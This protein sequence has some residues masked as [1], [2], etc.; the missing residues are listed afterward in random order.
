[1]DSVKKIEAVSTFIFGTPVFLNTFYK[2]HGE[3]IKQLHIPSFKTP[4]I[5]AVDYM[6]NEYFILGVN[7]P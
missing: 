1:M 4:S 6:M 3:P 5:G 7:R 2:I